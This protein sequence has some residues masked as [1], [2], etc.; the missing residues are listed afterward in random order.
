M[1]H[2]VYADPVDLTFRIPEH[3]LR[4]GPGRTGSLLKTSELGAVT[5]SVQSQQLG[6]AGPG[7]T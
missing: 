3:C 6:T 5:Q 1:K 4:V 7:S 2:E